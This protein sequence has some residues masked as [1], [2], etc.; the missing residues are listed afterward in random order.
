MRNVCYAD[1]GKLSLAKSHDFLPSS[2][3]FP[4]WIIDTDGM[5]YKP[6]TK[7]RDC[8]VKEGRTVVRHPYKR[9]GNC[10]Y[11]KMG[12]F[13]GL[14]SHFLLRCDSARSRPAACFSTVSSYWFKR[15]SRAAEFQGV[16]SSPP[17][18]SSLPHRS[19]LWSGIKR[20][21]RHPFLFQTWISPF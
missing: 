9:V 4:N 19:I 10:T 6:L 8:P 1:E 12:P 21:P 5:V 7:V 11:I 17:N 16:S 20:A 15:R 3:H 2:L 13:S 14:A 18:S